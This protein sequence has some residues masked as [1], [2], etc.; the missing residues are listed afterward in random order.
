MPELCTA[1][2]E[3]LASEQTFTRNLIAPHAQSK[4]H[5][6]MQQVAMQSALRVVHARIEHGGHVTGPSQLTAS[7]PWAT[8][9]AES[10]L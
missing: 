7:R 1:G 2:N 4:A 8:G 10:P 6:N 9:L 5:Q 3:R